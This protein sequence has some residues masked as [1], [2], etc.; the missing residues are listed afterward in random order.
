MLDRHARRRHNLSP[1]EAM[2]RA[3]WLVLALLAFVLPFVMGAV[4]AQDRGLTSLKQIPD[5]P[6]PFRAK[7]HPSHADWRD[8]SIYFLF[9]D[10]FFDGD[11]ANNHAGHTNFDRKHD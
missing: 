7:M 8:Q 9:P 1:G 2:R 5:K 3:F 11:P 4:G 10:R 6:K